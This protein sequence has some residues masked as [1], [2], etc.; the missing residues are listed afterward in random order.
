MNLYLMRHAIAVAGDEPGVGTD[1]ERP[2]SPKGIKRM[3]KAVRGLKRLEITFDALLTSPLLRARQTA[4]IVAGAIGLNDRVE[5]ISG[6]A[7]EGSVDKLI[8][9]LARFRGREHVMLVGHEPLLSQTIAFLL[10]RKKNE[11]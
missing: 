5:E 4:D 7:P 10:A 11:S 2:L 3:R 9:G 1:G 6:L 8:F